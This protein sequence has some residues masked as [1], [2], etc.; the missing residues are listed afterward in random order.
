MAKKREVVETVITKTTRKVKPS[1]THSH[2]T[3]KTIPK[4]QTDTLMVE[5]LVALQKAM[6]DMT[7]KLDNLTTQTSKLLNLF[8]ISA[9]SFME[10]QSAGFTS[11][12]K[13]FLEKLDK[14]LEQNKLIA[15]GLTMMDERVRDKVSPI[16]RPSP[17]PQSQIDSSQIRPK[18]L[19]RF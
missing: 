2:I 5:N 14:L 15:K 17:A 8:E 3:V 6:V 12:D 9:K 1:K 4:S 7:V 16:E 11:E 19:P 10:K 13:D 18:P